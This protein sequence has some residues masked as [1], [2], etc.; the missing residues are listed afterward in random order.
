MLRQFH[1]L[2]LA[3]AALPCIAGAVTLTPVPNANPKA[4]GLAAPNVL[5]PELDQRLVA[6]GSIKLD[7]AT[8][9]TTYYGYL[10]SNNGT[11]SAMVPV[12]GSAATPSTPALEAT[13]SEPDKN[14]YLVFDPSR[15]A[16]PQVGADPT[17][18]YGTHFAC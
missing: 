4:P 12:L 13:K 7:G 2:T 14:T 8:R 9:V 17:F 18:N 11:V 10:N 1:I 6:T 5:S 3:F 16:Q 15:G